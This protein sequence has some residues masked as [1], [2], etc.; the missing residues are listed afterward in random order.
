VTIERSSVGPGIGGELGTNGTA[1]PFRPRRAVF[2]DRDGTL[3]EDVGYLGDPHRVKLLPSVPRALEMLRSAGFLLIMVSN[4]S[5]VARGYLGPG[6]LDAVHQRLVELLHRVGLTLTGCYYCP[7]YEQGSVSQYRK[8]SDM[9]KPCCGMLLRAAHDHGLYLP[10]TWMVGDSWEDVGAGIG[11]G[12]RTIKLARTGDRGCGP[13]G[14]KPD[15]FAENLEQAA[16][17]I[18]SQI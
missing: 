14:L 5:G 8:E 10:L 6:D 18:L 9:R 3:M 17:I 1:D 11:A 13:G 4:Q 2:L 7:Y 16:T 15:F 12:V